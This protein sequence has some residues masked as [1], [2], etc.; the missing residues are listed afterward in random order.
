MSSFDRQ[1]EI[2]EANKKV[3]ETWLF[4][5][6]ERDYPAVAIQCNPMFN[7]VQIIIFIDK[8]L[9]ENFTYEASAFIEDA[10]PY[11][12]YRGITNRMEQLIQR[13]EE[14]DNG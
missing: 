11:E 4:E 3:Q 10:V 8:T 12:V 6:L 14:Q 2:R 5:L 9:R 1:L 7:T 13:M